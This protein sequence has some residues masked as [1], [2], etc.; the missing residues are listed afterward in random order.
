MAP[1]AVLITGANRGIGKGILEIYLEKPNH[2]AEG[3]T[4]H[5]IEIDSTSPTDSADAVKGLQTVEG[6]GHIDILI[7]NDR[8]QGSKMGDYWIKRCFLN[9]RLQTC[10]INWV[11]TKMG[12]RGAHAVGVEKAVVKVQDSTTGIV[13]I[14]DTSTRE[15]Y[16]GK[17]FKPTGNE[18][19]R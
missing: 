10:H 17:L 7:A 6:I 2:T 11:Q 4:L 16:S 1:T 12:N 15:T 14:I 13:K 19:P 3:T 9:S 5:V 18:E 8:G